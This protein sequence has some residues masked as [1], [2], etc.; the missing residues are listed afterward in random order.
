MLICGCSFSFVGIPSACKQ[1]VSVETTRDIEWATYTCTLGFHVFGK[2]RYS[3]KFLPFLLLTNT[4][5]ANFFLWNMTI[6]ISGKN[7]ALLLCHFYYNLS[8]YFN[9]ERLRFNILASSTKIK[10]QHKRETRKK[11]HTALSVTLELL[12]VIFS[13]YWAK[14]PY[15]DQFLLH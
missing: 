3:D 11:S 2:H 8:S 1:V 15:Q 7:T 14:S 5:I 12:L 9:P 6:H 13:C 4:W 10:L